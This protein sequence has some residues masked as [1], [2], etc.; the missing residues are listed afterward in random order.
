[1]A[2]IVLQSQ[3]P[4][5]SSGSGN[6]GRHVAHFSTALRDVSAENKAVGEKNPPRGVQHRN[7]HPGTLRDNSTRIHQDVE[8][9]SPTGNAS[10]P[11]ARSKTL[12][13]RSLG[14]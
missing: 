3:W 10:S 12:W 1:M 8:V 5:G 11:T 13:G 7:A 4:P 9:D 6:Q 2:R 14:T